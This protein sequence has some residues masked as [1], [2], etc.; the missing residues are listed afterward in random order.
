MKSNL[1]IE[2]KSFITKEKYEELIEKLEL[3]DN[4]FPQTNHYFD[5][6]NFDIINDKMVLR[7]RQ[8]PNNY[9]LTSKCHQ[10]PGAFE[11]HIF[12]SEDEAKN[13]FENGFDANIIGIDHKVTKICDLT[14]Y[15]AKTPYLN[16]ILFVDKSVYYGHTDYEI[17]FEVDSFEQGK[18]EFQTLLK[19]FD[20]PFVESISK[21]KRA[22]K[23]YRESLNK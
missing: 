1:E 14:T 12:I 2:F 17:E 22:Y 19:K 6:E 15:R 5:N 21:S 13:M 18:L 23:G 20:I 16:G 7:I 8:K 4:I 9:K 3:Q 11:T 10:E